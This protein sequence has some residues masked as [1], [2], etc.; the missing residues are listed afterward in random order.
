[1][2]T[3]MESDLI[4]RADLLPGFNPRPRKRWRRCL[5]IVTAFIKG[6]FSGKD[7]RANSEFQILAFE[8]D[9]EI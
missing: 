6:L 8:E 9:G 7:D 5:C 1:M 2:E 3:I 4:K